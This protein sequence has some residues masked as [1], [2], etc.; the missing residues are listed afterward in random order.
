MNT[1]K[2]LIMPTVLSVDTSQIEEQL[3]LYCPICGVDAMGCDPPSKMSCPHIA[4]FSIGF[5]DDYFSESLF[6]VKPDPDENSCDKL[7]RIFEEG[8]TEKLLIFY[9]PGFGGPDVNIGF[10]FKEWDQ[11]SLEAS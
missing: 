11:Y 3:S 5:Q 2:K 6:D 7:D 8:C 9:F 1:Q 10:S 4:I